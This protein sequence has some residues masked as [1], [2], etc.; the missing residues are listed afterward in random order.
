MTDAIRDVSDVAH[1]DTVT[2]Y[3]V[4]GLATR[5]RVA[6][7]G[8]ALD[9]ILKRHDYPPAVNKLVAEAA[10]LAVLLGAS[11]KEEG[12]F[13]LADA[14]RRPRLDAAGRFRRALEPARAGALRRQGALEAR[15]R[16]RRPAGQGLSRLH[17]RARRPR[18]ALSGRGRARR[19]RPAGGG[20]GIFRQVRADPD[21]G[22]SSPSARSSRPTARA[23]A[24]AASSRNSCPRA[25]SAAGR[26]ISHPGDAPE[27][28]VAA[29]RSPRT[30]P[31]PRPRRSPPRPRITNC[32]TRRCR[33]SG[34]STAC[35]TSA[36]CGSS[37]RRRSPTSAAARPSAST[38]CCRA[39]RRP[40]AR[41]WS[42]TTA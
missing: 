29:R 2:S 18:L 13:Q 11:L 7:L 12:R 21:A 19:P 31:G 25:R 35:S 15:A 16:R 38:R 39:F 4:E 3:T 32:S 22:A 30:T 5:G 8:A 37:R 24:P 28:H 9:A 1:D 14:E 17:H 10:A 42:A 20:G 33:A 36:A 34:C 40:S 26:P 41:R 27:G 23:G 6:R